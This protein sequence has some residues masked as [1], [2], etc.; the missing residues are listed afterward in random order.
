MR[1]NQKYL[2][3]FIKDNPLR[4]LKLKTHLYQQYLKIKNK[5]TIGV[6]K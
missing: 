6:Q 5:D 2:S 3:S 4:G 1:I